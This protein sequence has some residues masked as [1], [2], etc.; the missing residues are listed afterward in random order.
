MR[1]F[2]YCQFFDLARLP[3]AALRSTSVIGRRILSSSM[4]KTMLM[5]IKTT[6][7]EFSDPAR[8]NVAMNYL[9][10]LFPTDVYADVS[11]TSPV[12]AILLSMEIFR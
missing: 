12:M 10:D 2:Q 4:E 3:T 6:E 11:C 9:R 7:G 5:L 8:A 1:G